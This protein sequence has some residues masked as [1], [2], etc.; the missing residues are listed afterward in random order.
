M[1]KYLKMN[2]INKNGVERVSACVNP[3]RLDKNGLGYGKKITLTN[4]Y[5]KNTYEIKEC[6]LV[7]GCSYFVRT[8]EKGKE[9]TKTVHEF[10]KWLIDNNY[11][12]KD[13]INAMENVY[14]DTYE[15]YY[16]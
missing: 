10:K 1:F 9:D 13:F 15:K 5:V 8:I 12:D 11:S 14:K 2:K 16:N 6:K 4:N 3:F 7:H